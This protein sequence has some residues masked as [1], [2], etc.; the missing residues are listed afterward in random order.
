M[1]LTNLEVKTLRRFAL[2][3]D[4]QAMARQDKVRPAAI[5]C[6][7]YRI[8]HK[9]NVLTLTGAVMMAYQCGYFKLPPIGGKGWV[10]R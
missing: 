8:C 1:S 5:H 4:A 2:G 9:L 7:V 6:R 3:M 10:T